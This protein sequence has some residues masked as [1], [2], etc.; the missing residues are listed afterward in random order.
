MGNK[1][2]TQKFETGDLVRINKLLPIERAHFTSDRDAIIIGSYTDLCGP[3]E[4]HRTPVYE[5]FI[6]NIGLTAWYSES[7]LVLISHNNMSLLRK[8]RTK[9]VG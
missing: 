3:Q 4:A 8:W 1:M 2:N 6:E 7:D 5:I 9:I